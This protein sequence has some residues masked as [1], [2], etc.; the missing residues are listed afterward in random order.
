MKSTTKAHRWAVVGGFFRFCQD[1][2]WIHG[3]NPYRGVKRISDGDDGTGTGVFSDE[4]WER[5]IGTACNYVPPIIE[6]ADWAVIQVRQRTF[7]ISVPHF[8]QTGRSDVF[9]CRQQSL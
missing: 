2:G 8:L 1:Q 3:A 6:R 5:F 7:A 4:Q 9:R